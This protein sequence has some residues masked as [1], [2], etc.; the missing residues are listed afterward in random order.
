MDPEQIALDTSVLCRPYDRRFVMAAWQLLGAKVAILPRVARELHGTMA[1]N[2]RH[3]WR[4][5]MDGEEERGRPRHAA[6]RPLLPRPLQGWAC[7]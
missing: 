4:C 5:V 2:E 7:G 6:S 3:H 1:D